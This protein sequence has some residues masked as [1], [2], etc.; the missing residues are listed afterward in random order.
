MFAFACALILEHDNNTE[1][2]SYM[3]VTVCEQGNVTFSEEQH[4]FVVL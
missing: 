1:I 4:S 3:S 2:H